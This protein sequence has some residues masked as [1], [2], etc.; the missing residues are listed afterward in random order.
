MSAESPPSAPSAYAMETGSAPGPGGIKGKAIHILDDFK[1]STLE[2]F[3]WTKAAKARA[4]L[5]PEEEARIS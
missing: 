1:T 2:L 5:G 3:P 4:A